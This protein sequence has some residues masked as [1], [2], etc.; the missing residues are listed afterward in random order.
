VQNVRTG[1]VRH[2]STDDGGRYSV[3]ALAIGR[4]TLSVE[5]SGFRAVTVN[6]IYLTIGQIGSMDVVMQLGQV[7]ETVEVVDTTPLLQTQEA[8]LGQS[9]ESKKINDLPLN[10]RDFTQLVALTPGA[11]TAGSGWESGNSMVLINGHRSTKT[12][13]TVDGV[14]NL[15]S[16]FGGFPISPSPDA[17]QEFKV[18][19]GNFSASQG[20]GPSNVSVSIKSGTNS[21]HGTVYEFLR[22]EKLD[23]RNFF[24]SD[25][26]I[27]KRNQFGGSIGGPV[28]KDKLFYFGD[29][30]G[31]REHQGYSYNILVPTLAQR[32]GDFTGL[33]EII[34][35]TTGNP[36]LNNQI[37]A[38]RINEVA[39]YFM[40]YLPEPNSGSQ[41]IFSP[42]AATRR[43]RSTTRVDYYWND[44]NRINVAYTFN[45]HTT[46]EPQAIPAQGSLDRWGRSQSVALNW[47][48]TLSPRTMNTLALGW[49]R[50]HNIIGPSEPLSTNYTVDSGLQGYDQTSA[51]FPGWPG[52]Y[53]GGGYQ[54]FYGFEWF[55]LDN[56][57]E[58]RQIS[59]GFSMIRGGHEIHVGTDLRRFFWASISPTVSRG[60]I[61]YG[62][63]YTGDAWADFL[64]GIPADAFRQYPQARYDQVTYNLAG[65]VQDNWRVS[66]NVTLNLGMR[67]EYDTWPEES[68]NQLTSFDPGLGKFVVAHFPGQQPDLNAQPL[69]QL[70]WDLFGNYMITAGEA[71]LP[72]RTLRFPDKNNWGP[73]FGLAYRPGFLPNT[74]IRM[75]FGIFYDLINGN[76]NSDLTATAIPW[77]ISQGVNNSLPTPTL[78]NQHLF[79]P[80]DAPGAATPNIQPIDFDPNSRVPY[81]EEWNVS[82]QHQLNPTTS[83]DVAYVGNKGTKLEQRVPL[84]RPSSP[85]P[86][87][88]ET[89]RQF[90]D[91]SDGYIVQHAALSNYHALQV[92]LEK[93]YSNG[94]SLLVAY[95]YS[96]SIDFASNDFGS[97]VQD[98]NNQRAERAVSDFNYP[99]RLSVGYT[100]DLPFG[101]GRQFLSKAKGPAD[102]ILGGWE[103]A[104]ILT[105]QSGSPFTV[106][107][108]RD[109]ANVGVTDRADRIGSGK[110]D[111]PTLD[112]WFDTSAFVIPELYTFGNSGRNILRGDGLS[113]W[114]FSLLKNFRIREGMRLQF[115]AEFFNFPNHA[116][117]GTPNANLSSSN[118]GRV[119]YTRNDPRIGQ[120]ALKL[121]F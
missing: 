53:F 12:T 107:S 38:D 3:S 117:F 77:I 81:V 120:F 47:N 52:I 2:T 21:I 84:N 10:G 1:V 90:P 108:G 104:G 17:I 30:E 18:Q 100:Y 49:A 80:F 62:G 110:L 106:S 63:D 97:G 24:Q 71:G 102:A 116:D 82:I 39:T 95:T 34:D 119:T 99:Q 105:L 36:F 109:R 86:G 112:H 8:S 114:D 28:V 19:G 103:L 121:I 31:T 87:E 66:P 59:D 88:F 92:K 26:G 41:Y 5:H 25:R 58:N 96:R 70:A 40:Q 91:L 32:Q 75:G 85:G 94:M 72:T 44:N 27:L 55:P 45:Q 69:G 115:R 37:P 51:Q 101:K 23:A 46:G 50:Y 93:M 67:Y 74:A 6:D 118:L 22:N 14:M 64:L 78:D 65:Y 42:P 15:D 57:T 35:P 60:D 9:V 48:R 73:R 29:Y 43:D 61:D 83:L 79:A 7:S 113:N 56:P 76:N 16:L 98:M 89:R 4:Y 68:R 20:M 13:S 54:G 33:P 11:T 111:N